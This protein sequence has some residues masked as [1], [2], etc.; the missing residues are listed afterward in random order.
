M[1][2]DKKEKKEK[3]VCDNCG[4]NTVDCNCKYKKYA[5]GSYGLSYG[6]PDDDDKSDQT[7]SQMGGMDEALRPPSHK[8]LSG[9][10]K[11]GKARRLADFQAQADEAKKREKDKE[12]KGELASERIR[13]G[14]R[15]YDS[16]GSGYIKNGK[17]IYD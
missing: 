7:N 8:V 17:K 14:I 11:E 9:S 1:A 12:R 4:E 5:K 6:M 16:K 13:K 3:K 10:S 15:F 2:K